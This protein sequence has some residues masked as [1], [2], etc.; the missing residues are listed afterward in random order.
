VTSYQPFSATMVSS[1][2]GG[3]AEGSSSVFFVQLCGQE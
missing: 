3:A 2:L 1:G